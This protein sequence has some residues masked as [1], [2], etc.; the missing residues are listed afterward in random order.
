MKH[1]QIKDQ[2]KIKPSGNG[3]EIHE[4]LKDLLNSP[5]TD[6]NVLCFQFHQEEKIS[7]LQT[8]LTRHEM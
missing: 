8:I 6:N 2:L 1:F 7:V 3:V 4:E 5:A